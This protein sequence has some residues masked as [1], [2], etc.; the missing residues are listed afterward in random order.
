MPPIKL[1]LLLIAKT[2]SLTGG[3]GW[4]VGLTA[5]PLSSTNSKVLAVLFVILYMTSVADTAETALTF[6]WGYEQTARYGVIQ[7]AS[8]GM[9]STRSEGGCHVHFSIEKCICQ[10]ALVIEHYL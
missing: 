10:N 3:D 1:I 4:A 9:T 7:L 8:S 6:L 2:A 5:R